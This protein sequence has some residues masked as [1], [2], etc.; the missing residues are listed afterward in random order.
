[1]TAGK[2]LWA[3]SEADNNDKALRLGTEHY[4]VDEEPVFAMVS[5]ATTAA[6][7]LSV[8]GGTALG[9][10]AT[11][12]RL[13]TAADNTTTTG[14][15]RMRIDSNGNVGIGT[16]SPAAGL[17]GVVTNGELLWG[18]SEADNANKIIY[19]GT[20]HYDVD[21]EPFYP[22]VVSAAVSANQIVIGG[23]TAAV[24]NSATQIVFNTASDT[25]TT[26]AV[27]RWRI[28][29]GGALVA[30]GGGAYDLGSA[31]D[32]PNVINH[33]V[34]T[35]RGCIVYV[36]PGEAMGIL[37]TTHNQGYGERRPSQKHVDHGLRLLDYKQFP[38]WIYDDGKYLDPKTEAIVQGEEGVDVGGLVSL[39]IAATKDLDSRIAD[40]EGG[41][42][43]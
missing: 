24:G 26:T 16:T 6:N 15:E 38:G 39:L 41:E 10:A 17:H 31:S 20:E 28:E 7:T 43:E 36:D 21:E 37:R 3:D 12:I 34:L 13:F 14:T 19:F 25:T 8:G 40:L 35:D 23:D 22:I 9:N 1:V 18:D 27:A 29:S 2:F 33:K 5:V 4:D 11:I 42:S 30:V 32:Y